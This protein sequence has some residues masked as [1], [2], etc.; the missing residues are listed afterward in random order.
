MASPFAI[1]YGS[2]GKSGLARE[3]AD[4]VLAKNPPEYE[5]G[6]QFKYHSPLDATDI[7]EQEGRTRL[8]TVHMFYG[9]SDT[10]MGDATHD[11]EIAGEIPIWYPMSN[12]WK[13]AA[14]SDYWK[15]R[16]ALLDDQSYP[17]G[18]QARYLL[19]I[20]EEHFEE[21]EDGFWM[22]CPVFALIRVS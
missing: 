16:Q 13:M 22:K 17:T 18:V 2:D 8:F 21:T 12:V 3:I 9:G 20:G 15:I 11:T 6:Q 19:D 5:G 14:F 1:V 4:H 7:L 10:D